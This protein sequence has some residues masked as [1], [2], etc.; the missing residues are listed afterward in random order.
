MTAT[1]N[2]QTM[3]ELGAA[4]V[5]MAY[6][7]PIMAD[8]RTVIPVAMVAMGFRGGFGGRRGGPMMPPVD[9]PTT[10]GQAE[11]QPRMRGGMMS[12]LIV[13]PVGFIDVTEDQSRFVTIA[14]GRFVAFGFA[15]AMVVGGLMGGLMRR[16]Y[17]AKHR[18]M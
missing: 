10:D 2:Q 6:G 13:R 12:R 7:T 3:P 4:S 14:P 8:G 1:D 17:W 9:A 18:Q 16:R 5:N 11:K 15:L